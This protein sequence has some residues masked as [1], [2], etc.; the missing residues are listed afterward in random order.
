MYGAG[1]ELG[2][3]AL[4]LGVFSIYGEANQASS[5][6]LRECPT[7][8]MPSMWR[9][10]GICFNSFLPNETTFSSRAEMCLLLFVAP[11]E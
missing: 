7:A 8:T 1:R 5:L 10:I 9:L 2:W 3:R 6:L 11:T 4:E